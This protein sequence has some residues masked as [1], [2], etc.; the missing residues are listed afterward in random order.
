LFALLD[1]QDLVLHFPYDA[2]DPIVS[3]LTRAADDP[4]VL[5][6]KQ[7]LYRTSGDSP[8]VRALAR[9]ADRGKQVTVLVELL[10]RFDEWS[11]IRWAQELERAGAHVIYGVRGYKTHAKVLLIVRR[12]PDGIRRYVHLATGNYN[13]RTALLYTDFGLMTTDPDIGADAASF[14]NALT[15]YSDPPD[16]RKLVMA[17]TR[18]RERLIGLIERERR[19][20]E[21]GQAAALDAKMNA[22]VD[23]EIIRALYAA[24]AAGVRIRLNV[25]GICCLRPGVK[26]LSETIEVVSVVDRYLEHARILRVRNGGDD[27]VFLSSADWMSRNLDRRIELMFPVEAEAARRKVLAALEAM[28]RD[29]VKASV[30]QPDGSWRRRRPGRGEEPYRAQVE[31]YREAAGERLRAGQAD[32]VK[33][34]PIRQPGKAAG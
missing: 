9:A 32:G 12:S 33:L 23:E 21:Q 3:L 31:L 11:N 20:A 15:G 24:S 27:Q 26:G 34:E 30:L 13:D 18:L 19:R 16:M 22:L 25:R 6:I 29:D 4:D 8:V 2:F 7:T 28:F 17:P 14:F 1:G 10:A 5:A